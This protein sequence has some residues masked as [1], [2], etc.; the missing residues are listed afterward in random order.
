MASLLFCANTRLLVTAVLWI[1]W[2]NACMYPC[3]LA[4]TCAEYMMLFVA[5]LIHQSALAQALHAVYDV[6][7]WWFWLWVFW[8]GVLGRGMD[9]QLVTA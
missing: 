8:E 3:F 4:L 2:W 1:E 9:G 5:F 6:L 7:I